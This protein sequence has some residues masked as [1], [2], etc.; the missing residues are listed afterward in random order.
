MFSA[1]LVDEHSDTSSEGGST[2]VTGSVFSNDSGVCSSLAGKHFPSN[3]SSDVTV[4]TAENYVLY[5][6][7]SFHLSG[8]SFPD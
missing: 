5:T 1:E 4:T 6:G 7:K 2:A 3:P 8:D